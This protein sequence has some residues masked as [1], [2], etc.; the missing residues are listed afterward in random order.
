MAEKEEPKTKIE[1][2]DF[3]CVL[4]ERVHKLAAQHKKDYKHL[5]ELDTE[6]D[7]GTVLS[8]IHHGGKTPEVGAIMDLCPDVH[9]LLV[10]YIRISR[11]DYDD[12]GKPIGKEAPLYIPNF[13]SPND[14]QSILDGKLGRAPGSG[15]KSFGW[16]LA[17]VQP[18]EVDN[19]ITADLSIYFQ[20]IGDFFQSANGAVD[21]AGLD[22]PSFL[23][24]IINS[25]AIKRTKTK[26]GTAVNKKRK[27]CGN[28]STELGKKYEG[29]NF[30]IKVCAGWSLPPNM[31]K[32]F[33]YLLQPSA[34][35]KSMTKLQLLEDAILATRA[36]LFL[37]QVRHDIEFNQN[38]SL[39][40]NI[41][42][43]AALS[44]IATSTSSDI[45]LPGDANG[46]IKTLQDK[47]KAER[48][49][50]EDADEDKIENWLEE[51]NSL[52]QQDRKKKYEKLLKRVY[53]SNKVYML[54][55][56]IEEMLQGDLS[57]LPDKIR[58]ALAKKRRSQAYNK[59]DGTSAGKESDLLIAL[60]SSDTA[61][62]GSEEA[63]KE[64][65]ARY[66]DLDGHGWFTLQDDHVSVPFVYLGDLLD[67]VIAE[68]ADNGGDA[69]DP[70]FQFFVSE[71]EFIDMLLAFQ[72][73]ST[74]DL[75]NLSACRDPAADEFLET[76]ETKNSGLKLKDELY[77]LI[78]IGDIPISLDAFQAFFIK[79]VV[80]KER[81]KYY[82]LNFVKDVAAKLITNALGAGCY[83]NGI[84]FYQ[85]FDTQPLSIYKT[86][87]KGTAT[88]KELAKAKS[89]LG[90]DVQD[91]DKFGHAMIL[92]ST[93]GKGR[94]L[95]GVYKDDLA[96][97]IYHHYIGSACGLVKTLNFQREDQAY[98]REAKI[99]KHGALGAEQLRELYSV[100]IEL[101]GNNLYRNGQYIYVSPLLINT[102]QQQ[103]NYL[104][105]HGYYLI[106]SVGSKLTE[107]SFTTS[108]RALQEG[109]TFDDAKNASTKKPAKTDGEPNVKKDAKKKGEKAPADTSPASPPATNA[110][111]GTGNGAP[112]GF[113]PTG[114]PG[115]SSRPMT[116][117][118]LA[119]RT[120]EEVAAA[121]RLDAQVDR[122][123]GVH[124]LY[125]DRKRARREGITT[126]EATEQR[127]AKIEAAQAQLDAD[128]EAYHAEDQRRAAA[129][130]PSQAEE[131]QAAEAAEE[132]AWRAA[133][134]GEEYF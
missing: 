120:P 25:P 32:I 22:A 70:G 111:A 88:V 134:P 127:L 62:E 30:R 28:P 5:I 105:L 1:A 9:S 65:A 50:G 13:L 69:N 73:S 57:K 92:F 93:D 118:E 37:Q 39:T 68:I 71:V 83:S 24:L 90:C 87:F 128:Q 16:E 101:V 122:A 31:G 129:G 121:E 58:I 125:A 66:K 109:I 108:I 85:R 45:F 98:L 96:K 44:G 8:R 78:D 133:N 113:T 82:F 99:Q 14:V 60:G 34:E 104:G 67:L 18:A 15:I 115:V 131:R 12:K 43:Q 46:T 51:Q 42:Y 130:E 103:L 56:T 123:G 63:T 4:L 114:I 91:A 23:D 132:A 54:K 86:P 11:V 107:N 7:T 27:Q 3:Q 126:D 97:G 72:M 94:G 6:D 100:N 29:A 89:K 112:P 77:K 20:S 47:I 102:T 59:T 76:L 35:D 49:N 40:L 81:N 10:P 26:K 64:A 52:E 21:Q 2:V 124:N 36:S 95:K 61:A 19:N 53:K 33:P 75:K 79:N 119:A 106:T 116:E 48:A 110:P 55:V 117:E 80:D 84:T 74:A 41:K 17:G 38:G